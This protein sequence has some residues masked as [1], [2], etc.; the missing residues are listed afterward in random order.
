VELLVVIGI[1]AVLISILLPALAKARRAALSAEC[2]SNLRQ[3]ALGFTEYE[4]DNNG[5]IP[6]RQRNA[7]FDWPT[8]LTL[9]FSIFDDFQVTGNDFS[10]VKPGGFP[11]Y[12]DR[13][14]EICPA[15]A[16]YDYDTDFADNW[17]A[18][19][20]EAYGLFVIFNQTNDPYG[21]QTSIPLDGASSIDTSS[22]WIQLQ[23]IRRTPASAADLIMLADTM[24]NANF[25]SNYG[26][27]GGHDCGEFLGMEQP[28][29][30]Q[31]NGSR[32]YGSAVQTIHD[33]RANCAFY[34][35]HCESLTM[36][37]CRNT[38]NAVRGF[39][40]QNGN[41]VSLP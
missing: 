22:W 41:M 2:L 20:N 36:Q 18:S 10:T 28:Y 15:N 6:V 16:F 3:C 13:K 1:I 37:D 17:G 8:F 35:G 26:Y 21:F 23:N 24:E 30:A 14:V 9:G 31:W 32:D 4:I 34:D 29:G 33:G 40:D 12:V 25:Y 39:Y 5:Y 19:Q 27:T 11:V 38:P 7:I